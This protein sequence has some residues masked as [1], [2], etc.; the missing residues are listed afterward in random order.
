MRGQGGAGRARLKTSAVS[1]GSRLW[2]I[3]VAVA[4]L[5]ACRTVHPIALERPTQARGGLHLPYSQLA[6]FQGWSIAGVTA[7]SAV[8][9]IGE[10]LGSKWACLPHPLGLRCRLDAAAILFIAS[11][12]CVDGFS[13]SIEQGPLDARSACVV[14]GEVV[15]GLALSLG[16]PLHVE[17]SCSALPEPAP[18]ALAS[19][20]WIAPNGDR[21][22]IGAASP[23]DGPKPR[24]Y[25]VAGSVLTA[26]CPS[27][28]PRYDT[29][30]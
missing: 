16:P 17:T 27:P 10:R 4:G 1:G 28:A 18:L 23:G 3:V 6:V 25:V 19:A 14:F 7:G 2:L 12:D 26:I 20:S 22:A 24:S 11:G 5:C 8:S 13:F 15:D 21:M 9:S 29:D 30:D